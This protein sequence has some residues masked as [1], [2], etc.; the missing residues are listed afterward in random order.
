MGGLGDGL[1]A[2][3]VEEL[4]AG[5]EVERGVGDVDVEGVGAVAHFGGA[6]AWGAEEVAG[7]EVGGGT[8]E[9]E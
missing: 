4:V 2:E 6:A 5:V 7:A 3:E 9:G 1:G 8:D